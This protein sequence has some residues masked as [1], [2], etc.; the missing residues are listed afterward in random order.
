MA[1]S[2]PEE[3]RE[4]DAEET[5]GVGA[6]MQSTNAASKVRMLKELREGRDK[7][8]K[9]SKSSTPIINKIYNL[10]RCYSQV[11]TFYF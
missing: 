3:E 1:N 2:N 8:R 7:E 4:K 10:L 9:K 11:N 6:G 5:G